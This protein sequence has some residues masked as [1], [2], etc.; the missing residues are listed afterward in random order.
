M[1]NALAS[2]SPLPGDAEPPLACDAGTQQRNAELRT[3]MF[4]FLNKARDCEV[5]LSCY[6]RTQVQGRFQSM[7][8]KQEQVVVSGL[9]TPIG[10][11]SH[12]IIRASDVI[13]IDFSLGQASS[14]S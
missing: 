12:A 5:N 2:R 10:K 9:Q 8:A 13:A 7:D 6:E 11:Y 14:S 1:D 4:H 3:K